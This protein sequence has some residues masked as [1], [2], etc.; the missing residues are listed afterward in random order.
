M[1]ACIMG[2]QPSV[3]VGRFST[4]I[5]EAHIPVSGGG[6]YMLYTT[7]PMRPLSRMTRMGLSLM[8]FTPTKALMKISMLTM[9]WKGDVD[10][11]PKF[12]LVISSKAAEANN[13]TT[14]GRKP[15][16]MEAMMGLFLCRSNRRLMV[17]MSKK[18]GRITAN[19]AVPA[20]TMPIQGA[21]PASVTAA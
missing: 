6:A 12:S 4:L 21:Y 3:W 1:H 16:K 18:E 17:S 14:A 11:L 9:N 19:V 8:T 15:Q 5:N 13:P 7:P 2:M 10:T 20:P